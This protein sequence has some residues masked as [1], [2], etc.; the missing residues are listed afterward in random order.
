MY[1][2]WATKWDDLSTR[3]RPRLF[4]LPTLDSYMTEKKTYTST[5]WDFFSLYH[6]SEDPC[7]AD[8]QMGGSFYDICQRCTGVLV[9]G[10]SQTTHRTAALEWWVL[11]NIEKPNSIIPFWSILSTSEV[12]LSLLW[13]CFLQAHSLKMF[14]FNLFCLSRS[15]ANQDQYHVSV[16][17]GFCKNH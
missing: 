2:L 17:I 9:E 15:K 5:S 11:S 4:H 7:F 6:G 16:Y 14:Y 3:D 8:L 13:S 12:T 10:F 1:I